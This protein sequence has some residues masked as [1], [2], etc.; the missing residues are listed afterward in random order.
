MIEMDVEGKGGG[1]LITNVSELMRYLEGGAFRV[2]Y[3]K[4][5]AGPGCGSETLDIS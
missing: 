1:L 5:A 2:S 3:W 4:F